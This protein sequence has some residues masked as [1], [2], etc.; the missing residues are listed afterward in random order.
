M[1]LN[2]LG[3]TQFDHLGL[4]P[5][6]LQGAMELIDHE[7][8]AEDSTAYS[9]RAVTREVRRTMEEVLGLLNEALAAADR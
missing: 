8:S 2:P 5:D 4:A 9:A 6:T 7:L 1:R 3:G